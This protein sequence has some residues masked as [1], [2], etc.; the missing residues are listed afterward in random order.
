MLRSLAIVATLG[1]AACATQPAGQHQQRASAAA[2]PLAYQEFLASALPGEIQRFDSGP[3]GMDIV[4]K[5][6]ESY[7]AASGRTCR[8]LTIERAEVMFP[9][10]TCRQEAGSWEPVRVLHMQGRP[11]LAVESKGQGAQ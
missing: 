11:V 2:L 9:G 5:A 6:Q 3:W 4:L 8:A 1:L 10:L 7:F